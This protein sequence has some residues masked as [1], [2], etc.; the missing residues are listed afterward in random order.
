LSKTVNDHQL[1]IVIVKVI[2]AFTRRKMLLIKK[3][4]KLNTD[5]QESSVVSNL[6]DDFPPICKQDPP[7][8]RAQYVYDHWKTT[9]EVI[10]YSDIP[11]TMYGGSLPIA[12]KRKSKKKATSEVAD[13][14]EEASEPKPKKAK[15]EKGAA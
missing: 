4:T 11:D 9:G 13:E 12:K 3:V 8:V 2:N 1:G 15:K 14:E 6:M 7:E 10:K 5:L